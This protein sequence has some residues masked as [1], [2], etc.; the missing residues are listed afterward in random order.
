M[1]KD[2]SF[3][4]TIWSGLFK[5]KHWKK[6]GNAIWL[7][8]MLIDKVTKEEDGKGYVLGGKPV[9]YHTFKDEMPITKRQ[10][11]RYLDI[12]R[13]GSYI[14]THNTHH[15]LVI[16]IHNSKKYKRRSDKNVTGPAT[17]TSSPPDETVTAGATDLS[18]PY[19]DSINKKETEDH[20]SDFMEIWKMIHEAFRLPES[21]S[22]GYKSEIIET[23]N[24]LGM[25]TTVSACKIFL[26]N[27]EDHPP[28]GRVKS[29]S[30]FLHFKK[31]DEYVAMIPTE[32]E[33]RYFAC[34][35]CGNVIKIEEHEEIERQIE[36][37]QTFCPDHPQKRHDVTATVRD[38]MN[39]DMS[40]QQIRT[41]VNQ[42]LKEVNAAIGEL[43]R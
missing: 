24:R 37:P 5:K 14:H 16:I 34:L 4:L 35:K 32:T 10:Y 8:G 30:S 27:R 23:I 1:T 40:D 13:N 9:T 25:K 12:L 38:C 41:V 15:G 2:Q 11:L 33:F 36:L 18:P 26:E 20:S 6:M 42:V 28:H 17:E 29:I 7:F 3:P 19:I 43:N 21:S 22:D 39:K 31:I